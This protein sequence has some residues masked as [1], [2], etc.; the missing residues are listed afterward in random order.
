MQRQ[1]TVG[2]HYSERAEGKE[3]EEKERWSHSG[4]G[5]RGES[6]EVRV[7]RKTLLEYS[8]TLCENVSLDWFN[9]KLN[10]Q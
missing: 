7:V 10:S 2:H 9:R 5:E 6:K 1:Q 3:V 4:A 8:F